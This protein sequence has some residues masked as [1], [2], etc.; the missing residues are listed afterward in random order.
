MECGGE[1]LKK[2]QRK[3]GSGEAKKEKMI[4]RL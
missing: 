3:G 4:R 1:R 2:N